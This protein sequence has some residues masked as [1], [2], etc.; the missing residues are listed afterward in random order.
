MIYLTDVLF[1]QFKG[2]KMTKHK[3]VN[4]IIHWANG[5]EIEFLNPQG[6]WCGMIEP[7]TWMGIE[8]RIKPQ[9]K[10]KKYL[11]AYTD[12]GSVRVVIDKSFAHGHWTYLGKIEVQ[13]D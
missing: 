1:V 9:L 4:E 2:N 12:C 10:G 6:I 3:W 13:N 7:P 5:G 8:Y 11:Y